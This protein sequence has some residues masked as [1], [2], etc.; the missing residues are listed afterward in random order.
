MLTACMCASMMVRRRAKLTRFLRKAHD[1]SGRKDSSSPLSLRNER[2]K[3]FGNENGVRTSFAKSWRTPSDAT[4]PKTSRN[5]SPIASPRQRA[6]TP[7]GLPARSSCTEG[8]APRRSSDDF[9]FAPHVAS[10]GQK[11]VSSESEESSDDA[12]FSEAKKS[13]TRYRQAFPRVALGSLRDNGRQQNGVNHARSF[14]AEEQALGSYDRNDKSTDPEL[15]QRADA[16]PLSPRSAWRLGDYNVIQDV[17]PNSPLTY[18]P[19]PFSAP[20]SPNFVLQRQGETVRRNAGRGRDGKGWRGSRQDRSMVRSA[21]LSPYIG[22]ESPYIPGR[23]DSDRFRQ[24]RDLEL[25]EDVDQNEIMQDRRQKNERR[26]VPEALRKQMWRN[27]L[28]ESVIVDTTRPSRPT[29]SR[30]PRKEH[31][32]RSRMDLT[33]DMCLFQAGLEGAETGSAVVLV[34]LQSRLDLNGTFGV[35]GA[36]DA[37]SMRYDVQVD[38][39]EDLLALRPINLRLARGRIIP[40]VRSADWMPELGP[41]S[42]QD[43]ATTMSQKNPGSAGHLYSAG[44]RQ[45]SPAPSPRATADD[46]VPAQRRI[47]QMP[48]Q[49]SRIPQPI[50]AL[51]KS[52]FVSMPS[53]PRISSSKMMAGPSSVERYSQSCVAPARTPSPMPGPSGRSGPAPAIQERACLEGKAEWLS[54]DAARTRAQVD[55]WLAAAE[56]A[57]QAQRAADAVKAQAR[58]LRSESTLADLYARFSAEPSPVAPL[59]ARCSHV[60]AQY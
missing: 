31:E 3:F 51:E 24:E 32:H 42:Q 21:S 53:S 17:L 45:D 50:F 13:T 25:Y 33:Q 55:G 40:S 1:E 11:H 49:I 48:L 35:L 15:E 27:Q 36:F 54:A 2:A 52:R 6:T 34:G 59:H 37:N 23:E 20:S 18:S 41:Q 46:F 8:A 26:S 58:T 30:S 5:S 38:G 10:S 4:T 39:E 22:G 57:V 19:A 43:E 9:S 14:L 28:A 56:S 16:T 60:L 44:A 12:V 47:K 7:R 29:P